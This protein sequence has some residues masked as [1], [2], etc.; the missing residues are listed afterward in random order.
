[1]NTNDV[2]VFKKTGFDNIR[3]RQLQAEEI[4]RRLSKI[5]SGHL[6]L[7]IGGK[8][9]YDPHAARV[10][11]GFDPKVKIDILKDLDVP[12]DIIFCMNYADIISN[13]QL[14]NRAQDYILTSL[15]MQK[16]IQQAFGVLPK[17]CINNIPTGSEL[18]EDFLK[19][20]Q[21]IS[22]G[23]PNIYYR[24]Y[25]D[26]YPDN[27]E[28]ILSENGFGK[29]NDIP[30]E[31]KLV[32]VT[33][34]ASN[35]GKLSTCLGMI[36]KDSLKGLNSGYTKYE[37]FPIWNLPL[38]HPLNLAYEAATA[39]IGD[40]NV[41]DTYYQQMYGKPSV[42]YNRDLQAFQIIRRLASTGYNS[43]TEM[44]VSNAGFAITNDEVVCVA[45][46]NEIQ[47]RKEWYKQVKNGKSAWVKMCEE[48][49]QDAMKYLVERGYNSNLQLT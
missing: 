16:D 24:Y 15:N 37:T 8:L 20:M 26:G 30:L 14:N 7:E 11:P 39:D 48:L 34:S 22:H 23:N 18:G 36:Y 38:N 28:N 43:P 10:L 31:N 49:E 33:G 42:N 19:N 17:I 6:Y 9:F 13:R 29:D 40:K 47:H 3:Y 2:P 32:I 4:L 44:G 27:V 21:V 41:I 35:S 5:S 12:F 25:I 45:S 46:L 1:M